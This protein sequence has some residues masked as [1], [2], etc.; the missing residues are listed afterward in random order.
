MSGS[1]IALKESIVHDTGEAK[2]YRAPKLRSAY[3]LGKIALESD[4]AYLS[5]G[6]TLVLLA[7]PA[8]AP[9]MK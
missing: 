5:K 7:A 6:A 3:R 1:S 2:S 8:I 4:Y 9:A